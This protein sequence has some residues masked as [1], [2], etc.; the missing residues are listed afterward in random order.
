MTT[1]RHIII[2][3]VHGCADELTELIQTLDPTQSDTVIFVGDLLDKGPDPAGAVRTAR[4]LR[5]TTNVILVEGNHEDKHRRFRGHEAR[6][7]ETGKDNPMS[8]PDGEYALTTAAL[9]AADFEFLEAAVLYHK[10]PEHNVLVVHGGVAPTTP[11]LPDEAPRYMDLK[12]KTKGLLGTLLRMRFIDRD[13]GKMLALGNQKPGDPYWADIYD[14]RFGTVVFGH[15][16]FDD[17]PVPATFP[18]ALG[19][20]LGCVLGGWLAALVLHE[21]GSRE[22][23][24]VKSH[25]AHSV[26]HGGEALHRQGVR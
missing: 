17:A 7:V 22:F 25:G 5:S 3:D 19:I 2:G 26:R 8:D 10:I 24:V 11:E 12:G 18:H 14:G 6:K 9:S 20:D 16:V 21:D 4:E 1:K 15:E 13:T 23:V